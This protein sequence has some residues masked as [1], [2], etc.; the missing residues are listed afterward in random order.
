VEIGIGTVQFGLDYGISNTGG[1]TMP[2]DVS[3]ILN[4]GLK[5][6]IQYIDTAPAYEDSEKT[7]GIQLPNKHSYRIITKTPCFNKSLID[8]DDIIV[9][10]GSINNSLKYLKVHQLY[11]V[12]FH[13]APD[14]LSKGGRALYETLQSFKDKKIIR[15]IG[16]S[17]YKPEELIAIDEA[18]DIDIVQFPINVLDQRFHRSGIISKM[19]EKGVELH[20]RSA[21]LQGLLLMPLEEVPDYFKSTKKILRK[22]RN[23]LT[24]HNLS[25][26]QGAL[27]YIN[28]IPEI[29]CLV[30]GVNNPKQL[31]SNFED[32]KI[33]KDV[34]IDFSPFGI[35]QE[36]ILNPAKWNTL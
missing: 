17:V 22:Y 27:C 15:K 6:G 3:S 28:Q 8:N 18:Y 16:V 32:I 26:V 23:I 34:N 7:I 36:S 33:I 24:Q 19:K 11:G 14:L 9:L 10:K 1:K 5:L 31:Q 21:F 29:D 12:L 4:L 35:N 25:S 30:L 20:G 13:H 2:P